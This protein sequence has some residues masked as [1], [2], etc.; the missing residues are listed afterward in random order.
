MAWPGLGQGLGK[1]HRR[2]VVSCWRGD[3]HRLGHGI[4]A[5]RQAGACAAGTKPGFELRLS[6]PKSVLLGGGPSSSALAV[7]PCTVTAETAGLGR[8]CKAA[9][10]EAHL[11]GKKKTGLKCRGSFVV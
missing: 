9:L 7:P 2:K 4:T 3:R 5:C 11:R 8:L 6:E 1:S 10:I